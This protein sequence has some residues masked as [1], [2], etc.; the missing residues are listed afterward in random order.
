MALKRIAPL[1]TALLLALLAVVGTA[2]TA[3]AA[4]TTFKLCNYGSDY[5]VSAGFASRLNTTAVM[6]PG[7]CVEV[8]AYT[9]EWFYL[10][11]RR[12]NNSAYF[13]TTMH[14]TYNSGRTLVQ[15]WG[16]FNQFTFG[17][18]LY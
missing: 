11:V 16:H 1:F 2:G 12:T 7:A 9:D 3:N 13:G 18:L 8:R 14:L 6:R 10:T 15:T 5:E 17:K 4:T